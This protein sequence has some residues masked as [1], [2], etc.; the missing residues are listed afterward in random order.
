M[1]N[2]RRRHA[3]VLPLASLATWIIVAI[4]ACGA[5]LY[6]VYC[7]HQLIA[8]GGQIRVLEKELAELRNLNEAA[9]TRIARLSSAVALRDRQRGDKI[10]SK[11][12]EITQD[13]LVYVSER[14]GNEL[15]T[16]SNV[17]QTTQ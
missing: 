12:M 1:S 10:L 11:Y 9:V 2:N 15:R 8:R 5:G 6:Y 3:N 4:F 14:P 17:K 7:K 16:V 13:H